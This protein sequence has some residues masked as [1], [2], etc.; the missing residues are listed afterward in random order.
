MWLDCSRRGIWLIFIHF[1]V[2]S[3]PTHDLF[4]KIWLHFAIVWAHFLKK[5]THAY[6]RNE[7]AR[8]RVLAW[9]MTSYLAL[10]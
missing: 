9:F 10:L 2:V 7:L 5:V 8:D 3:E 4:Y 1:E 6:S